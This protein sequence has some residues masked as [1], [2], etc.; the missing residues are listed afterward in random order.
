MVSDSS[1]WLGGLSC[2]VYP[3]SLHLLYWAGAIA[4]PG[5]MKLAAYSCE[6]HSIPGS[7]YTSMEYPRLIGIQIY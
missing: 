2:S 6:I 3:E 5:A 7:E 1:R 4:G